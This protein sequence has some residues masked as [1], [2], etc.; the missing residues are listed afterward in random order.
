MMRGILGKKVGMTQL[1]D[2]SGAVIP[3]TVIEAGPCY[4]A[5]VKTEETD[6]YNAIQLG[7]EEVVERKL[8]RGQKGHLQNAEVPFLRRLREI[9]YQDAPEL[10][11]GDV[12]KADIFDDGDFVAELSNPTE[13]FIAPLLVVRL[14]DVTAEI[15]DLARLLTTNEILPRLIPNG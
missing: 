11:P 12:V 14:D 1:F 2:E 3:V 13:G 10:S 6:G 4:V 5:Q 9:R 15:D 7:F 8:T